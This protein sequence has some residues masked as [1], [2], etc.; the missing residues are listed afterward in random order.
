MLVDPATGMP[1]GDPTP[2]ANTIGGQVGMNAVGMSGFT[3]DDLPL[4]Y[5]MLSSLPSATATMGWNVSRVQN[6][7]L[8]GGRG[9]AQS[10][11]GIR[12]TFSPLAARRLA[13][14]ANIDPTFRNAGIQGR[15]IYSPF[16]F[17]SSFGN[18]AHRRALASPRM[19][20]TVATRMGGAAPFSPGSVGRL[21]TMS[22]LGSMSTGSMNKRLNTVINSIEDIDPNS[23]VRGVIRNRIGL[24]QPLNEVSG[25]LQ[26]ELMNTIT[27]KYSAR[28]V[29]FIR[30]AELYGDQAAFQ[31]FQAASRNPYAREGVEAAGRF[32]AQRG[33]GVAGRFLASGAVSGVARA[34][35]PIGWMLLAKDIAMMGGKLAGAGIDLAMDAGKSLQG[36]INKPVFGMGFKDNTVA[37]TARQRGVMAISNSRLNMRSTLGSEASFIHARF[38]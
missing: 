33:T 7:I 8:T 3:N 5:D 4:V 16:N 10:A 14:G 22:K 21:A 31:A 23:Q 29:G 2:T 38:G 35:G 25:S 15:G 34:A 37:A 20:D 24:G 27:G 26:G 17:L 19:G 32:M 30:G 12:Q 1:I 18:A 28:T 13:R 36:S 9:G 11:R 6:T